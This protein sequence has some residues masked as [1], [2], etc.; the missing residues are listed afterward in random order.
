MT[1][2]YQAFPAVLQAM[3]AGVRRPGYE[4]RLVQHR[5]QVMEMACTD[6]STLAIFFYIRYR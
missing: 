4:A 6:D 3:N 5:L 2:F 1:Q